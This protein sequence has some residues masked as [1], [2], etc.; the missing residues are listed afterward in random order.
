MQ[1][2]RKKWT[3]IIATSLLMVMI[4]SSFS[5]AAKVK[6]VMEVWYGSMSIIYNG[7]NVT[8]DL[9]PF[10]DKDGNSYVPLRILSTYFDK[11]VGW[12]PKTYT[13]TVTDKPGTG[14]QQ[15]EIAQLQN[16]ILIK[17]IEITELK[18][19]IEK[20]EDELDD[21][22]KGSKSLRTLEKDLNNDH[23]RYKSIDFDISL[24]SSRNDK[25]IE[26]KIEVDLSKDRSR[27][28]DLS[29]RNI[30]SY[31][32]DVCKDISRE[33]SKADIKGTIRDRDGRKDLVKFYTKSN[34]DV[35]IDDKYDRDGGRDT[36]RK[37]LEKDLDNRY[38]DY[39]RD[40]RFDIK[41]NGDSDDATFYVNVDLKEYKK[42]W[43]NLAN[44]DIR[45]M[46]SKIYDDIE[47][48]WSRA[49]IKGYVY[50]K[51]DEKDLAEYYKT[52]SGKEKF[53]MY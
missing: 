16:K 6:K 45:K 29:T 15:G 4:I 9:K 52:S 53:K 5:Y 3:G 35:V 10:V 36:S 26:V 37:D 38:Y 24:S 47:D 42:E 33:F 49:N 17:D 23:D 8:N 14:A 12:D 13:A 32:E 22:K 48:E 21:D 11:N 41:L 2:K 28:D 19:K 43:K 27:W 39:F 31:L 44:S 18:K 51:Y 40:I 46:M 30:E 50:D 20:L 1:G 34:G 25:E 7:K